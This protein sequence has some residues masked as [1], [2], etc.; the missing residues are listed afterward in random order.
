[1][2]IFNDLLERRYGMRN[3]C[4]LLTLALLAFGCGSHPRSITGPTSE[5]TFSALSDMPDAGLSGGRSADDAK[6]KHKDKKDGDKGDDG[7]GKGQVNGIAKS[8][9]SALPDR[10][11]G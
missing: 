2:R 6:A 1:M 8:G 5:A 7:K 4:G 10:C 9:C 11:L 3:V